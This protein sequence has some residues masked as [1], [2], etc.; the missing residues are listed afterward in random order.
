[1]KDGLW[2][3]LKT[4]L[5]WNER[6]YQ[7]VAEFNKDK[8]LYDNLPTLE[9]VRTIASLRN[10]RI[11]FTHRNHWIKESIYHC[12]VRDKKKFM[13]FEEPMQYIDIWNIKKS[14]IKEN[15]AS[16][17]FNDWLHEYSF[18]LSKST[19]TKRFITS[20][21]LQEFEVEILKDPLE[22]LQAFL[23]QQK[24]IYDI[25][26]KITDTVYL[27]LYWRGW[28]V[29]E[30]SWLNQRN[31]WGR[32]RDLSEIY[33][34]VPRFIHRVKPN[35]FPDRQTPFSLRLPNGHSMQAKICQDWWKALMS[36][37]NKELWEWILR[38]MFNLQEW[39]IVTNKKL[40]EI[41]IDSVRIDKLWEWKY[42]INVAEIDSYESFK[43]ENTDS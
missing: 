39:E 12:V 28:K 22:S 21:Y 30:S 18:L 26:Q 36:H 15:R 41:W 43:E 1:M 33:I 23:E 35:F 14:N 11:D 25:E 31:A 3:G 2:F 24:S 19:L 32:K 38:D 16:I 29:F 20:K 6:S 4:F 27:P 40:E 42:E 10:K 7:K 17:V 5:K 9:K 34:P 37:S 13:I 8:K